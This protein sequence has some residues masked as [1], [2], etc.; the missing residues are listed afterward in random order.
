MVEEHLCV[1]SYTMEKLLIAMVHVCFRAD[2]KLY[3]VLR[4]HDEETVS[5]VQQTGTVIL[6]FTIDVRKSLYIRI[7]IYLLLC[8]MG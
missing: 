1:H 2:E 7:Y 4:M 8:I 3:F 5:R 6:F